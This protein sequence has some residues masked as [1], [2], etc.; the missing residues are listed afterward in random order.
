MKFGVCYYPEH[1]PQSRWPIDAQMMREAGID[2]VRIGEFAWSKMEPQDGSYDWEWL[3]RAIDALGKE[4]RQVVLGTP[5]ATPPVWLSRAHPDILRVDPDG[6]QRDHGTRRQYCPNSATYRALSRRI[7][8]AMAE[9]YGNHPHIIGWQT[10]NEFGGGKTARCYCPNCVTAFSDWLETRY[11]SIEALNEAWGTVFWS[12]TYDSFDE[13]RPPH[14]GVNYK[15]PSHVL[16]FYRFSAD[17]YVS[18]Q[19]EQ[20]DIL[21]VLAPDHFITHNFMGLYRDLDQHALAENL[22][23]ATWDSYPTGFPERWRDFLYAPDADFSQNDPIYA[24][25]VG[26]PVMINMAHALTRGL[27]QQP[28]WIMEQ[29]CGHINWAGLNPQARP[30]TV[31]L[32]TWQS[33]AAGANVIV[34]FR[35]RSTLYAQEQYHSGLLRHDGSPDVGYADLLKM[36]AERAL[37]DAFSEEPHSAE[38]ALLF[39]WDDLW[40]LELQPHRKGFD[41]MRHLFVY[42][43][44]LERMGVPVDLVSYRNDLSRYKLLIAPTL[45][46]ADESKVAAVTKAV[47]NGATLLLGVRSGFK[48]TSNLVTAEPLPGLL[49]DLAGVT[50][51]SWESLPPG[52]EWA[53]ESEIPGLSEPVSYWVERIRPNPG[54]QVLAYYADE[55]ETAAM[56]RNRVTNG[57]VFYVGWYPNMDQARM[58]LTALLGEHNIQALSNL[59]EGILASK[60]GS[61]MILLNF[62]DVTHLVAIGDTPY[63]VAAR[64]IAVI[65]QVRD[66]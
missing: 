58:L 28:F 31:R 7:V 60:R 26:E 1:W 45:H 40:S 21:R 18:Y 6:S 52:V 61:N 59:P 65:R 14:A 49:C 30:G 27:K 4:G 12:Q 56:T 63:T 35:W 24:Y 13:I 9:R 16:D 2:I 29:Q 55:P 47:E 17:S 39:D 46:I 15:N 23:F 22:D 33:V 53:V 34:Y 62:T 48:T 38:I 57:T 19:Q 8:R 32:W 51:K 10:D 5:T 11:A 43:H 42:Y 3:D 37:L 66:N 64:D 50:V 41:L 44:A 54:T 36:Q 20:I 25:D